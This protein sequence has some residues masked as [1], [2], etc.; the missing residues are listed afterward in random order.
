MTLTIE[1]TYP[2]AEYTIGRL[3]V[4]GVFLCNTLELPWR[5]NKRNVSCIPKGEYTVELSYSPKFRR[6]TPIV[7]N[8]PNRDCIRIHSANR[9]TEIQGCIAVGENT[10]KGMVLNSR[11]YEDI[12]VEML[13]KEKSV[14]LIIK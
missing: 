12:L 8:V 14:K 4:D 13:T 3:Y 5:D 10:K 2:K 6:R 9:V 7:R 1:R 11:H